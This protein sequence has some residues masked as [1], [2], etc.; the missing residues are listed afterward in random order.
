MRSSCRDFSTM[1]TIILWFRSMRHSYVAIYFI[2]HMLTRL[3]GLPRCLTKFLST[4][5]DSLHWSQMKW[6]LESAWKRWKIKSKWVKYIHRRGVQRAIHWNKSKFNKTLNLYRSSC[7]LYIT[8]NLL[9]YEWEHSE[10]RQKKLKSWGEVRREKKSRK[11]LCSEMIPMARGCCISFS[12]LFL[13]FYA[14]SFKLLIFILFFP[15]LKLLYYFSTLLLA[16]NFSFFLFAVFL[17]EYSLQFIR[18]CF[19]FFFFIY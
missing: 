7:T 16:K 8:F 2:Y 17:R 15:P 1:M 14:W 6:S 19:Y 9:V 12:S 13:S 4:V 5:W 10:G 3:A 18:I 11:K